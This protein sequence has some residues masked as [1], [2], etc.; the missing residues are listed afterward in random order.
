MKMQPASIWQL[1]ELRQFVRDSGRL[2]LFTVIFNQ[3]CWSAPYRKPTRL[4]TNLAALRQ[5]GPNT[6][7]SFHDDGTYE[8]PAH[9]LYQ[10]NPSVSL[11]RGPQDTAFRTTATSI[12]PEPMDRAIAMAIITSLHS[13]ISASSSKEGDKQKQRKLSAP[14]EQAAQK[15]LSATAEQAAT[16]A[17]AEQTK[18]RRL[19]FTEVRPATPWDQRPGLGPPMQ[20]KYK[21]ELRPIHDGAGVCSPGR[22]PVSKRTAPATEEGR[23]LSRWFLKA[24]E[25]W[26]ELEGEEKAKGLFW[27]AAAGKL[28]GTPFDGRS[29]VSE[30]G[31]IFACRREAKSRTGERVT[32][33]QRSTSGG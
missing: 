33:R 9:N 18:R 11:A 13:T 21:G 4:L 17:Q 6:W 5:W 16:A 14:A 3:C 10:C 20:T 31:W 32:G 23:E 27:K 8:G 30:K 25:D 15:K 24:F 29:L 22:W 28:D 2:Q 26:V 1:N 12:Y 7:P 19:S